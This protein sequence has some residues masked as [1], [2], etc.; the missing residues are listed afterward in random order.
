MAEAK[1]PTVGGTF[2]LKSPSPVFPRDIA[3]RWVCD[4]RSGTMVHGK[5]VED[6]HGT[7]I[8]GWFR[9]NEVTFI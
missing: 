5:G 1:L 3:A 7:P 9:I 2:K 4:E 6:E 8:T